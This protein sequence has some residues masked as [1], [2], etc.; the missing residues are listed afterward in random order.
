MTMQSTEITVKTNGEIKY[1]QQDIDSAQAHK[2]LINT[3][4]KGASAEEFAL[5]RELC[6]GTGLNPF[7]REIWFI[8]TK[9]RA[10]IMT[11]INGFYAI[12]NRH[13]Q[14]DGTEV[15]TFDGEAGMPERA[16][17]KVWRKDRRLP[18]I[19]VARWS[20]FNK[21]FGNW[22]TMPFYMLEKCAEAI[23]LR[24]AFPQELNEL[25]AAEEMPAEYSIHNAPERS[26]NRVQDMVKDGPSMF[27]PENLAGTHCWVAIKYGSH[28]GKLIGEKDCHLAFLRNHIEKYREKYP[29]DEVRAFELRIANLE[30]EYAQLKGDEEKQIPTRQLFDLD[31]EAGIPVD[32][33]DD[34]NGRDEAA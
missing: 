7:K 34:Y 21:G 3:V 24:K 12:A 5:F 13:A 9:D 4:A 26:S 31:A 18:S 2:L 29:V 28:K 25:Y 27:N 30:R 23:A 1:W 15:E 20:E 22:K 14:Y 11:G 33:D 8:K 16:V 6:R 17:A 10:Q 32:E 19:G